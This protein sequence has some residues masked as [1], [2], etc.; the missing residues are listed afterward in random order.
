MRINLI[1]LI[2][3]LYCL[4]A[5]AQRGNE[6]LV[7]AV[8][9]KVTSLFKNA[10]TPVKV[11]K[12]LYPGM[13][14]KT[15]DNASLTML[16]AKGKPISVF[17]KGNYPVTKWKDSCNN[18]TNSVT[19]N[20]FK[21]IWSQLYAYSPENKEELRKRNDMAVSRGETF[22][23]I[24]SKKT[25]KL[26]FSKGMDTVCY[27]GRSFPL[28]WNISNY[29]GDYYF[30]LYDASGRNLLYQDS[31]RINYILLDSLKH[32]LVAGN[33]YKWSVSG[34]GIP[35]SPKKTIYV[36]SPGEAEKL[37]QSLLIPLDI[38]EDTAARFFR[39]AYILEQKHYLAEAYEWYKKA[40]EQEAE[41][42]LYLDQLIRFRNEF[43][44]R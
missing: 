1:L 28:S 36:V 32:L 4:P 17:Q 43:W 15:D 16:C 27:D 41:L 23:T 30:K 5:N 13:I 22:E 2:A 10:E 38:P 34:K 14:L 42:E 12:V 26:I 8:K 21:Y 24:R 39:T 19:A 40:G 25:G 11:G 44:L 35:V 37:A 7:Y 3:V 33:K 20:Y 29:L 9:G 31:L 6:L 18:A